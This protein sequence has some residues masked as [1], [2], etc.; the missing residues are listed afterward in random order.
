MPS[1]SAQNM[2]AY[3]SSHSTMEDQIAFQK[4]H[5]GSSDKP[6][7]KAAPAGP[8]PWSKNGRGITIFDEKERMLPEVYEILE[9][10]AP[11][12]TILGTGHLSIK[13]TDA[14]LTAAQEIGVKRLLVTHPEYMA[15]MSIEDQIKWRDKGVF[16]ERCYYFTNEASK[17]IGGAGRFEIL[18]K[19]IRTVGVESSVLGSD[20][21]QLKNEYPVELMRIYLQKL[22]EFGFTDKEIEQMAVINPAALLNL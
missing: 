14:L 10:M 22:S 1:L 8:R 13:E 16:L 12:D 2:F 19:N 20:G 15:K 3:M 6:S 5:G 7:D 17:S 21:G 4:A 18:A 9:I 11:S